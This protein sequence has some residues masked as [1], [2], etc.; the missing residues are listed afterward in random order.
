MVVF[1]GNERVAI[2]AAKKAS[3]KSMLPMKLVRAPGDLD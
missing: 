1:R 2:G 3:R